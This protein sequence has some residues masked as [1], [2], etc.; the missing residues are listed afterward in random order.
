MVVPEYVKAL[1]LELQ[2]MVTDLVGFLCEVPA[3]DELS[4]PL[5]AAYA[6]EQMMKVIRLA[7]LEL[8]VGAR[9]P[10]GEGLGAFGQRDAVSTDLRKTL[11]RIVETKTIISEERP[12]DWSVSPQRGLIL[13][14]KGC[15][16]QARELDNA[17]DTAG[18]HHG[19]AVGL[20][21]ALA[22]ACRIWPA[23]ND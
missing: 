13:E 1:E 4:G 10:T 7:A 2:Q 16:V 5:F 12:E 15:L 9:V 3:G 8:A 22:M 21:Q 23:D 14:L 19:V 6:R 20:Q 18:Y 17:E 11:D